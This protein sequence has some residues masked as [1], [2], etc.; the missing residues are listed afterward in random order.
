[1]KKNCVR[2]GPL[3]PVAREV[4]LR[5]QRMAFEKGHELLPIQAG[6]QGTGREICGN[7]R[8]VIDGWLRFLGQIS[9]RDKW[10][11]QPC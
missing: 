11:C 5:L 2:H 6:P 8:K 9:W 4:A 3:S 1:M 10:I 7:Y